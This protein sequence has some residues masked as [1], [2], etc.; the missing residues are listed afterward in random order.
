MPLRNRVTPTGELIATTS[1]GTLMGN[2]GVLHDDHRRI[3]RHGQTR[4]WIICLLEF[5]GR[6]RTVM[7]PHRY[8]ELFFLD[9]A[10]ALA[11]GHRPCAECRRPEY[12]SYRAAWASARRLTAPPSADEMDLMLAAER[13]ARPRRG[14]AADLPPGSMILVEHVPHLVLGTSVARWTPSGYVDPGPLPTGEVPILT[15][16]TTIDALRAGYLPVL[17]SSTPSSS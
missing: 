9:E 10:T 4:R 8:T 17:H 14:N 2:R 6:R 3:V 11:A 16:E 5:K 1:R 13:R 15:P 12:N 7:T